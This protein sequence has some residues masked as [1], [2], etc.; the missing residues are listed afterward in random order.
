MH[1][2][3]PKTT[4]ICAVLAQALHDMTA[5][6]YRKLEA[7]WEMHSFDGSKVVDRG[8]VYV[9]RQDDGSFLVRITDAY[10]G[11]PPIE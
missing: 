7:P 4:A 1:D 8:V 6:G 3:N 5:H 9:E 2:N 10:T 11:S